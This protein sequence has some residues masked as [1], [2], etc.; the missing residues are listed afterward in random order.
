MGGPSR[1]PNA[2]ELLDKIRRLSP[3]RVAEV[4]DFVDFLKQRDEESRLTTAATKLSENAFAA[5][6]DSVDNTDYDQL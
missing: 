5:V 1:F 4:E 6:W 3:E 2:E